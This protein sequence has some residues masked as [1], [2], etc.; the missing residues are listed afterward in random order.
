MSVTLADRQTQL[1]Y[2]KVAIVLLNLG[3]IK[4]RFS[5]SLQERFHFANKDGLVSNQQIESILAYV[6]T[7]VPTLSAIRDSPDHEDIVF[8]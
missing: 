5:N 3:K 8:M 2:V 4:W 1:K 6:A 7:G